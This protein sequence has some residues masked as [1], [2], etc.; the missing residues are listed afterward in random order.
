MCETDFSGYPDCRD[1]FVTAL[2]I[3]V[4]L[5]ME[6]PLKFETPLMWLTKAQTWALADACKHLNL[7]RYQ[8]LTCYKGILGSGCGG[9]DACHLRAK[10]LDEYLANN[11][12]TLDALRAKLRLNA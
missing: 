5:G 7:I 12:G 9:C 1:D 8:K 6:F 2:N 4:V 10:G 3:A 11:Q